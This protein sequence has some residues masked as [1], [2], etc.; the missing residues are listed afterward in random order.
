MS[1]YIEYRN[2]IIAFIIRDKKISKQT[3]F[4]GSSK[5]SLQFGHIIKKRDEKISRHRHKRIKRIIYG[6]P[7]ILIVKRG[8]TTVT[9]YV[10]GKKIKSKTLK[11]GDLISLIDCEHSFYFNKDTVLQ[12]IKQGPYVNKEKIVYD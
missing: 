3:K 6:T 10:K 12:E 9:L 11:K 2:K 5:N 7:E 8:V 1:E 4:F